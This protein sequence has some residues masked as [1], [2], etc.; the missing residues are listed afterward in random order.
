MPL[1]HPPSIQPI[2]ARHLRRTT[3]NES[4][5]EGNGKLPAAV[6]DLFSKPKPPDSCGLQSKST[7]AP[8]ATALLE[9]LDPANP[10]DCLK[11]VEVS[12][13]AKLSRAHQ[14]VADA[15]VHFPELSCTGV[16][17]GN[18]Y[19]FSAGHCYD[20]PSQQRI[21]ARQGLSGESTML[22]QPRL[23]LR[24]K[25]NVDLAVYEIVSGRPAASLSLGE[26]RD[27]LATSTWALGFPARYDGKFKA[28][29]LCNVGYEHKSNTWYRI[30]EGILPSGSTRGAKYS[31][32]DAWITFGGDLLPGN[33]GGPVVQ[34]TE[35][36]YGYDAQLVGIVAAG[37]AG[38]PEGIRATSVDDFAD[39]LSRFVPSV[40]E[41]LGFQV[42]APADFP[43]VNNL[44]GY[45]E[46]LQLSNVVIRDQAIMTLH[47]G[48]GSL[49]KNVRFEGVSLDDV[50][51]SQTRFE[52]VTFEKVVFSQRTKLPAGVSIAKKTNLGPLKHSELDHEGV[53]ETNFSG[54]TLRGIH[55]PH[56]FSLDSADLSNADL[57]SAAIDGNADGA[58]FSDANL[59][60]A[61]MGRLGWG[62]INVAGANLQGA[63]IGFLTTNL[64]SATTDR[65][66]TVRDLVLPNEGIW[67]GQ[68][69][70]GEGFRIETSTMQEPH[71]TLSQDLN[72]RA[73][74]TAKEKDQITEVFDHLKAR[75]PT[76]A[77]RIDGM[78]INLRKAPV[79][80]SMGEN[81]PWVQPSTTNAYTT[82]TYRRGD[83]KFPISVDVFLSERS[84]RQDIMINDV[85]RSW[86]TFVHELVHV[87]ERAGAPPKIGNTSILWQGV[88]RNLRSI[89]HYTHAPLK[90]V[91]DPLLVLP[92]AQAWKHYRQLKSSNKYDQAVAFSYAYATLRGMPTLYSLYALDK[93]DPNEAAADLIAFGAFDPNFQS[94]VDPLLVANVDAVLSGVA[95]DSGERRVF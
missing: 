52:N 55:V 87:A 35:K 32:R 40:A 37:K 21:V 44:V 91:D 30:D 74:W 75:F 23:V 81:E 38:E 72:S 9:A 92:L 13:F 12:D 16:V 80:P 25:G 43:Q 3:Q 19:V 6:E 76:F 83:R 20:E 89:D 71:R 93:G 45:V 68:L 42:A 31:E 49:L 94:Y 54:R 1:P 64:D 57:E 18:K 60:N 36:K 69:R 86:F 95:L 4:A 24:S 28:S 70:F 41:E 67:R 62:T 8:I 10:L 39:F 5:A 53:F 34:L 61:Q 14:K 11:T 77:G 33:S 59:R 88:R 90:E 65:F 15:T 47:L 50:D 66:T 56:Y 73:Q 63:N 79:F 22:V 85:P 84:L 26:L 48:P 2:V 29:R 27:P 58:D 7:R 51:F 17:V 46:Q 78:T 82:D